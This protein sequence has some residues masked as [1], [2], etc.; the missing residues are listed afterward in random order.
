MVV[1]QCCRQVRRK[2][3]ARNVFAYPV[4]RSLP[5]ESALTTTSTRISHNRMSPSPDQVVQSR[6]LNNDSIVIFFVEGSFLEVVSHELSF[7]GE[8]STFLFVGLGI[9]SV[10]RK[11]KRERESNARRA[12]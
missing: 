9:S 5:D 8:P 12:S 4:L 10:R 2:T 7:Q 1:P 6:E 11:S 3:R